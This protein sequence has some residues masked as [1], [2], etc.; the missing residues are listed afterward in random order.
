MTDIAVSTIRYWWIVLFFTHELRNWH[1]S[2]V[3]LHIPIPSS[4]ASIRLPFT[5]FKISKGQSLKS[6][7]NPFRCGNDHW[8]QA[9]KNRSKRG[10]VILLQP[11]PKLLHPITY[12]LFDFN[13]VNRCINLHVEWHLILRGCRSV[14]TKFPFWCFPQFSALM[15]VITYQRPCRCSSRYI[16]DPTRRKCFNRPIQDSLKRL[17]QYSHF[18]FHLASF[19]T[20]MENA[21]KNFAL[22]ALLGC[23]CNSILAIVRC[24]AVK[25]LELWVTLINCFQTA[26]ACNNFISYCLIE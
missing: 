25:G 17:T 14:N 19:L 23:Y 12:H 6:H 7:V 8:Q 22:D 5:A 21:K 13:F 1:I 11:T 16:P 2:W 15:K 20:R 10:N 3:S 26:A 18:L 9:D 4:T 24:R